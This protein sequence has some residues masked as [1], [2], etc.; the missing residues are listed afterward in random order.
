MGKISMK[1]LSGALTAEEEK[2]ID[3]ACEKVI[4]YDEDS[5][6]MTESMLKQFHRFDEIPVSIFDENRSIVK[7]FGHNYRQVLNRLINMALNDEDM[8]RKCL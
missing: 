6:E 7:S 2:E 5:P 4:T 1:N 3:N 8:V